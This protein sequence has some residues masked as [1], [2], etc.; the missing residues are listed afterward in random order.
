MDRAPEQAGQARWIVSCQL[1]EP[2]GVGAEVDQPPVCS[3]ARR[4]TGRGEHHL[5]EPLVLDRVVD[6]GEAVRSKERDRRGLGGLHRGRQALE[7]QLEPALRHRTE[8]FVAVP[9]VMER[10]GMRN[11]GQ[12]RD[13]AHGDR[14]R[15]AALD[16]LDARL[17]ACR[18][19]VAV[20][21]AVT[22]RR[23]GSAHAC[24]TGFSPRD[25]PRSRS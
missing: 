11:A 1:T 18:P 14:I 9:E 5:E 20:V 6:V 8:Q 13:T 4:A 19:E 25:L 15:A 24:L 23:L 7:Q 3:F 16:E 2:L 17:D 21:V 12:P 10:G 22:A